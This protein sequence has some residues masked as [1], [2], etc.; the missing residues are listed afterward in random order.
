VLLNKHNL[1][2]QNGVAAAESCVCVFHGTASKSLWWKRKDVT[3]WNMEDKHLGIK[4]LFEQFKV[5]GN[6]L[7]RRAQVAFP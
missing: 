1:E 5:T 2:M 4:H 7:Q 3:I 6:A